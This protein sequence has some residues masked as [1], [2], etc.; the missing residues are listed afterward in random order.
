MDFNGRM[1]FDE[2][3][4][5]IFGERID[6]DEVGYDAAAEVSAGQRKRDEMRRTLI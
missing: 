2:H 5:I 6:R 3:S 1:E 4:F